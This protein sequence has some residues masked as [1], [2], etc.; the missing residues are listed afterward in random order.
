MSDLK[1]LSIELSLPVLDWTGRIWV[2]H[3][4]HW[5][6]EASTPVMDIVVYGY[7]IISSNGCGV[8][9]KHV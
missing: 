7:G 3:V 4:G 5:L 2:E 8:G 6:R 1:I 9:M